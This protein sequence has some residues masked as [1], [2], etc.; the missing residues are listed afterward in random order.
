MA[1]AWSQSLALLDQP[2]VP[3]VRWPSARCLRVSGRGELLAPK[4]LARKPAPAQP[5]PVLTDE[6]VLQALRT[7]ALTTRELAR[8]FE[9]RRHAMFARLV[10][11][12][13]MR[14]VSCDADGI[15]KSASV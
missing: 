6:V 2:E 14:L 12:R 3:S 13:E 9:V 1:D 8:A 7:Q 15:W 11:L 4:S 5:Q 10:R